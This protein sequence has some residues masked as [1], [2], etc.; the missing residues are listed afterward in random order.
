MDQLLAAAPS[1]EGLIAL[2]SLSNVDTGDADAMRELESSSAATHG[3]TAKPPTGSCVNYAF[4]APQASR[5]VNDLQ[6]N[7][8]LAEIKPEVVETL[9]GSFPK[10][11][12]P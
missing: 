6:L 1:V 11:Y 12:R 7:A 3:P 2:G 5:P 8:R 9:K 10:P 4:V